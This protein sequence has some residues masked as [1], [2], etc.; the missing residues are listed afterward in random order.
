MAVTEEVVRLRLESLRRLEP[1]TEQHV[2]KARRWDI[3]RVHPHLLAAPSVAFRPKRRIS[4]RPL[5]SN[6]VIS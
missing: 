1:P 5:G 6:H 2:H 4:L 3:T